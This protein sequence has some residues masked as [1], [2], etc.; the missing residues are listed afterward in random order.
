MQ[1]DIT[2]DKKDAF[3]LRRHV[4]KQHKEIKNPK[5]H[6]TYK[7][8]FVQSIKTIHN[9]HEAE[10][11]GCIGWKRKCFWMYLDVLYILTEIEKLKS[12]KTSKNVLF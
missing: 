1:Q 8:A 5:I 12:C 2:G 11:Q 3:A 9:I 7:V 6:E 10:N 4:D